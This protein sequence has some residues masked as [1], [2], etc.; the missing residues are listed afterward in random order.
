[1]EA[2]TELVEELTGVNL[3]GE[4]VVEKH[5]SVMRRLQKWRMQQSGKIRPQ[6]MEKMTWE[7]NVIYPLNKGGMQQDSLQ[8]KSQP[9]EKLDEGVEEIRK[10][11]LEVRQRNWSA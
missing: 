6:E 7:V 8:Q 9:I 10:L 2:G 11:M 4:E 3:S 1:V 5:S